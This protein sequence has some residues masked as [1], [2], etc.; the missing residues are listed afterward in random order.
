MY[1]MSPYQAT[2]SDDDP[3]DGNGPSALVYNTK[4]VQLLASVASARRWE[5]RTENIARLCGTNLRGGRSGHV[6]E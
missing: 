3:T 4:T 2:E 6:D 1:A 5:H